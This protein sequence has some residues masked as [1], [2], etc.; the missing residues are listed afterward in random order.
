MSRSLFEKLL[1]KTRKPL[2]L[3]Q[4]FLY[5]I[6]KKHRL[7][8]LL[9]RGMITHRSYSLYRNILAVLIR[10]CQRFYSK[11]KIHLSRNKSKE[12]LNILYGML[13]RNSNS[14]PRHIEYTNIEIWRFYHL[15]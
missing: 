13:G 14:I 8:K 5:I 3:S 9:N 10:K 15:L 4:D 2:W 12:N 7:Y 1:Y 11:N 6:K